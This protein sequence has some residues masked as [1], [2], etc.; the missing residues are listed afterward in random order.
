MKIVELT[1]PQFDEYAKYHPFTNYCQT[2]KYAIV[3]TNYGFTYDF[4]GYIDDNNQVKAASLILTKRLQGHNYYG[5]A[6]KGFLIDYSNKELTKSFIHDIRK[7]YKRKGFFLIKFNPEIIIGR[8]DK[9]HGFRMGYSN[10]TAMIDDFK[11]WNI[12]RRTE[13]QEFDLIEPKITAYID[14]KSYNINSISRPFRKKIRK[15]MT[16]GLRLTVGEA[17]DIEVFYEMIKNKTQKPLAYFRDIYN[18][19]SKDNSIDLV[20]IHVDYQQYIS[21]TQ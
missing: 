15:S 1:Q 13:L 17:K 5:Y 3:M 18:V 16:K 14:L 12:K 10:N 20:F 6:P 2:S 8:S 4:I 19:F 11:K 9:E 7:F 21:R